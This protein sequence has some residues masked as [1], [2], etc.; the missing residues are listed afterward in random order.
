MILPDINILLYGVNKDAYCHNEAKVWLEYVLS[1]DEPT[2]F[3]WIVLLGFLRISTNDRIM[4]QPLPF[5]SAA[6][7]IDSW[8]ERPLSHIVHPGNDHWHIVK[9]LLPYAGTAG[10]LTSDAHLAALAIEHNATLYSTD[11]DFSRFPNL[12]WKNP[13]GE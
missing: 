9:D 13:V 4:T 8:L 12:K 10:N 7:V 3:V 2:G 6:H 11:N 1:S 5:K